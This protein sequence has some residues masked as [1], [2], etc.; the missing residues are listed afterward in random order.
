MDDQVRILF[1]EDTE[2]DVEVARRELDRDGLRFTWRRVTTE[3]GL[4]R[5]LLEFRPN[6]VLCDHT[7]PG[8][9]AL[10]EQ[11]GLIRALN[12]WVLETACAV[13][14]FLPRAT[15]TGNHRKRV[16][17]RCGAGTRVSCRVEAARRANCS[18]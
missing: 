8:F 15:G 10:A 18:G 12:A 9:S 16:D 17:S 2:D 3:S 14:E 7:M 13:T 5:A 1:V 6:V 11:T 4:W